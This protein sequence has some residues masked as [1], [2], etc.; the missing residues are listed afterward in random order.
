VAR[1]VIRRIVIAVPIVLVVTGLTFV[2]EWLN[3][4]DPAVVM[5]GPAGTREQIR[6]L[7]HSMGFDLPIWQQYWHWLL[8]F[9]HGDL[10]TSIFTGQPVVEAIQARLPVTLS[11]A[12]GGLALA[13]V[14][15]VSFGVVAGVRGGKLGQLIDMT[16][17]VFFAVPYFWLALVLVFVFAVTIPLFPAIGYIDITQSPTEWLR[18]LILPWIALGIG[19]MCSIAKQTRDAM[20]DVIKRDYIQNLRANGLPESSIIFRHALRGAALPVVTVMGLVFLDLLGGAI[21]IE[22]VFALP[23]IGNLAV[24]STGRH[25]IPVVQGIAL[26]FAIMVTLTNLVLDVLYGLLNTRVRAA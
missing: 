12:F 25:D 23:G 20:N 26:Y 24:S 18:S 6:A 11:L 4:G 7:H 19:G 10:G 2:L 3:P 13:A 17:L 22:I 14:L 5:A 9:G 16:A 15:G 8:A 1:L 21:A